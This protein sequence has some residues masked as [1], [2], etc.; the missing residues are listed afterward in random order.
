MKYR[1]SLIVL[2]IGAVMVS[3]IIADDKPTEQYGARKTVVEIGKHKGFIL[4]P[5][6][7]DPKLERPWVWYAPTIGSYPNQSNEWVLRKL[8][9][10]GFYVCGVDVGES[11][12]SPAGRKV[13][14]E[15]YQHV[16]RE[17]NLE[18]KARLLAQSRG[19]L[20][21]Y[22]WAVENPEKVQCIVGIYPVCDLRSFP[23][24][25]KAAPAYGLKPEELEKQ[26]AEHNPIDRLKPLAKAGVPILH[27]HGDDDKV[28][29]LEPNSKTVSDRYGALGGKM[30]LIVI[31][32]KGHAEIPEYF[33][34]PRLVQFLIDGGFPDEPAKK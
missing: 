34:E 9:D 4:E 22:N 7:P 21:I 5:A 28:V 20:M 3:A 17:Y 26:H 2:F 8:L 32:A 13:F 27:I 19:G 31:P 23:G 11:Y 1:I 18:K 15:F 14:S 24:L 10:R 12:G 29:P 33:Q 6:K 16:V 25:V 30:K